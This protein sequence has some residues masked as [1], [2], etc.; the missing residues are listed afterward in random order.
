M[1]YYKVNKIFGLNKLKRNR[2]STIPI[3]T[4]GTNRYTI[5]FIIS[6]FIGGFFYKLNRDDLV[7][8]RRSVKI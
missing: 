8:I 3:S 4:V 5:S 6:A 1:L 7:G 2:T